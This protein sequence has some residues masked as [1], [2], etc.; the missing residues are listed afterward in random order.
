MVCGVGV[1]PLIMYYG[2]VAM[3]RLYCVWV[4]I[5]LFIFQ[6]FLFLYNM[7]LTLSSEQIAILEL[8]CSSQE[9]NIELA[10]TLAASQ[11]INLVDFLQSMGYDKLGLATAENFMTQE[12]TLTD[13]NTDYWSEYLPQSVIQ[14]VVKSYSKPT[15]PAYLPPN[16][17]FLNCS[18]NQIVSLPDNLP[19]SLVFLHCYNNKIEH[20]PNNLPPNLQKLYC[21]TN[22]LT[23][24]PDNLP[25]S[26]IFLNCN[27]NQ[28][29]SLP[30]NLPQ[31][32][33][34]L[35]CHDN[36]IISLINNFPPNLQALHC[37]NN[38]LTNLPDHL[39]K[40]LRFLDCS[41]NQIKTLPKYLLDWGV[42]INYE[43]NPLIK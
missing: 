17:I 33:N 12:L 8:L 31:N 25:D 43:D 3:Q 23:K 9:E 36:H 19:N 32:L 42:E 7:P 40:S 5:V 6:H 18:N 41:D 16:L 22:L 1:C 39:P 24:L 4:K 26:L 21:S 14:L 30:D 10:K 34:I 15:L 28:I 35:F 11:G 2:D 20:L 38:R 27:V 13:D 37:S 29:V